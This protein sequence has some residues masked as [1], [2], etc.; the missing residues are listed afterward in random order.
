MQSVP[1]SGRVIPRNPVYNDNKLFLRLK[2]IAHSKGLLAE[3]WPG[4]SKQ[5]AARRV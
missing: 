5:A 3:N 1:Q 2:I 4:R